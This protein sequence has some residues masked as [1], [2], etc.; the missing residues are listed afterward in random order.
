MEEVEVEEEVLVD[1]VGFES[2]DSVTVERSTVV[3]A[4][5]DNVAVAVAVAAAAFADNDTD[6]PGWVNADASEGVMTSMSIEESE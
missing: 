6:A 1:S 2:V 5:A 4:G 3:N